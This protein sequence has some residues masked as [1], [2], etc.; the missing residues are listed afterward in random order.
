MNIS[1][2]NT[3]KVVYYTNQNDNNVSCPYQK[4]YT[5]EQNTLKKAP[6]GKVETSPNWCL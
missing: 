2:W 5:F 1:N 6:K 4:D 3:S